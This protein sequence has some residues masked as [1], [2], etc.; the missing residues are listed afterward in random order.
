M[1]ETAKA[2]LP[3]N[4]FLL[5][6]QDVTLV[7]AASAE[8]TSMSIAEL[9]ALRTQRPSIPA[10]KHGLEAICGASCETGAQ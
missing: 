4:N 8:R 6:T 5:K 10:S 7:P 2:T 9:E 1:R 3:S